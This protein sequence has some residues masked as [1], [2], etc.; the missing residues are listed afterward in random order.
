LFTKLE[1]DY[2]NYFLNNSEFGNALALRNEYLH[3]GKKGKDVNGDIHKNNYF[4]LL[5]IVILIIIK[6]NDDLCIYEDNQLSGNFDS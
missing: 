3:G 2:F 5:R 4:I 1:T 6:I